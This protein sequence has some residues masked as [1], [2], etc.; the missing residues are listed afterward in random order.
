MTAA[1]ALKLVAPDNVKSLT[2]IEEYS[3]GEI[4]P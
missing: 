1:T 4:L 2:T 3:N